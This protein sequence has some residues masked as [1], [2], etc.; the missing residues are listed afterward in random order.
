MAGRIAKATI[1][2]MALSLAAPPSFGARVGG[3]RSV[4]RQAP[5]AAMRQRSAQPPRSQPAPAA[6]AQRSQDMAR[7][8]AP[9]APNPAPVRPLPRQ[10]GSPWGGMLGGALVGLG[11]G[12]LLGSQHRDPAQ[13]PPV[14][15]E[16]GNGDQDAGSAS[17]DWTQPGAQNQVAQQEQQQGRF[18]TA[19]LLGLAAL[20]IYFLVRRGR[21]RQGRY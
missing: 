10:A 8:T 18:G 9:V 1:F 20:V 17:G 12:S 13:Q 14:Q 11:L 19:L 3:G 21:R 7:Q 6:P 16:G 15:S 5:P 2:M 4:G